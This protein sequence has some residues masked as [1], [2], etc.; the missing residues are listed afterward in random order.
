MFSADGHTKLHAWPSEERA[1]HGRPREK[2]KRPGD[3]MGVPKDWDTQIGGTLVKEL[4]TP[5]GAGQRT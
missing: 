4:P 5:L 3:R 2:A 1:M